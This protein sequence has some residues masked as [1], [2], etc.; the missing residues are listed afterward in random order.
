[1]LRRGEESTVAEELRAA[2][3]L[4]VGV[5]FEVDGRALARVGEISPINLCVLGS[6]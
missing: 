4:R 3:F 1:M 5:V 6:V 2:N